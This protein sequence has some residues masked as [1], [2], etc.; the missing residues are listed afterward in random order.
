MELNELSVRHKI[1]R[2]SFFCCMLVIWVHTYN[3]D[4]C[5]ITDTS[6]GFSRV[7]YLLENLWGNLAGTAVPFFFF[8]SGYLF[9]RTFHMDKLREKYISRIHSILIPYLLWCTVYFLFFAVLVSIP[10]TRNQIDP[11]ALNITVSFYGWLRSLWP[12][13]YYTLWF[14]KELL[15]YILFC[16]LIWYVLKNRYT[17]GIVIVVLMFIDLAGV[18]PIP[19]D[20]IHYY[21]SGA[22]LAIHMKGYEY[23]RNPVLTWLGCLYILSMAVTGFRELDQLPVRLFFFFSVWFALDLLPAGRIPPWWMSLTFFI[24]VAH[25]L[26]L[27]CLEKLFFLAFGT[28]PVCALA[29]YVFMPVITVFLLVCIAWAAKKKIPRI[30]MILT[31]MRG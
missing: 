4:V 19:L 8:L 6:S 28:G 16:P 23:Y 12:D 13:E 15:L 10:Y 2:I 11:A 21:L 25:D 22:Y 18:Y 31:G 29:D 7:V 24:Y 17:G 1:T 27:E 3:L 30:F 14:L 26:V 9:Y 5:G 20:G